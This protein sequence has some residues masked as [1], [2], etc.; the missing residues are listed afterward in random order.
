MDHFSDKND[1]GDCT[2]LQTLIPGRDNVPM[3]T[4]TVA[5]AI[6]QGEQETMIVAVALAIEDGGESHKLVINP[7]SM[8]E[9]KTAMKEVTAN[10]IQDLI[11][12]KKL[13][14]VRQTLIGLL[15]VN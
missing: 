4:V 12:R 3:H 5:T 10:A 1:A 14:N 7:R 8:E 13:N 15:G 2:L 11:T 9:L 6:K